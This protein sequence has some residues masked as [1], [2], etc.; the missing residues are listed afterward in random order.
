MPYEETS[1]S[2]T[3]PV[4]HSFSYGNEADGF[5]ARVSSYQMPAKC[6]ERLEV[7]FLHVFF[8]FNS[9]KIPSEVAVVTYFER[10]E[11]A[12]TQGT[13]AHSPGDQS[14][15]GG[16]TDPLKPLRRLSPRFCPM[17]T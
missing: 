14:P 5:I 9:S 10:W 1:F 2:S 17:P 3:F 4:A 13:H 8:F 7:P 15:N 6:Q 16:K 11:K 12:E